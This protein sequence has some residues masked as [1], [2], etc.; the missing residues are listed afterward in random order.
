MADAPIFSAVRVKKISGIRSL[1]S[2]EAHGRREDS[3]SAK[4]CDASRTDDNLARSNVDDPLAV[5]AAF[6]QRKADTKATEY[7]GAPLGLHVLC[8]VSPEWISAAG[9][10][11]DPKNPRNTALFNAANKWAEEKF[12]K[13]SVIASRMDMDEAGGGVVDL[14][15]V[16]VSEVKQRGKVKNQISVNKAYE[17]AFGGGR[18]FP[19]MQDSWAEYCQ[20]CL[21]PEIQRGRPKEETQREHVHADIL[22]PALQE[23][24]AAFKAKTEATRYAVNVARYAEGMEKRAKNLD[25]RLS[26][27]DSQIREEHAAL[28]A[29][30]EYVIPNLS[31]QQKEYVR[32]ALEEHA[33]KTA[34]AKVAAACAPDHGADQQIMAGD[35]EAT[36]TLKQATNAANA[37]NRASSPAP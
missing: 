16:P 34:S 4:R 25:A 13:G 2:I 36:R 5:V 7:K 11:H 20:R 30:L 26:T 24:D 17:T 8:V 37:V 10:M 9:D 28:D 6:R 29:V 15:I 21:D 27:P 18:V 14:V 31:P 12:G 32:D 23:R 1:Q 19:K 22:R 33:P 35:D 3:A